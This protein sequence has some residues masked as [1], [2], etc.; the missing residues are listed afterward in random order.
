MELAN[1]PNVNVRRNVPNVEGPG[2]GI[3]GMV[4]EDNCIDVLTQVSAGP[5]RCNVL[6]SGCS[7]A[8]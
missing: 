3:S 6:G 2:R 8:T 7:R 1:V 5:G 4:E